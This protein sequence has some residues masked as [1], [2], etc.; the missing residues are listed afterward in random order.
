MI[1]L[2]S[3]PNTPGCYLYN[4][5]NGKI[6]YVGKAKD[7]KKR[8]S[9]YFKDNIFDPKTKILVS[10][11]KSVD[12]IVTNT[13]IEAL[14]LENNLIKKHSPK[15]NISLKDS[16]TYAFIKLTDDEFPRFIIARDREKSGDLYGPFVLASDRKNILEFINKSFKLRTCKKLP[17]KECLRFH[18]GLC[19][20][21]CISK[22]NEKD[23][24][25]LVN[26]A[27]NVLLGRNDEVENQ[28]KKELKDYSV[29]K[30]FEKAILV[31]EQLKAIN[32]LKA[33]QLIQ[34]NKSHNEH[35]IDYLVGDES[36]YFMV[37]KV[38]AGLVSSKEEFEFDYS[39]DFLTQFLVQYY[40]ENS[41]PNE[42]VLRQNLDEALL[43]YLKSKNSAIK[44]VVPKM[45]DKLKM[46]DLVKKNIKE[47]FLKNVS[48][49]NELKE[50]LSLENLPNIIEG[51]DISH[52]S[53][54]DTVASMVAF[55]KGKPEKSEYRRFKIK[56]LLDEVDDFKAMKEVV[57]RRY[58][59][60]LLENKA[61]PDL[62][63]VDGGL[64]QVSS[65]SKALKE[66]NIEIA[67]V[68]L[69]KKF[70][71]LWLPN[72]GMPINIDKK[73]EALKLLQRV[74][75][76]AHRFANN[77]NKTLRSKKLKG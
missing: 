22:I 27:K 60:L 67:I 2:K 51:F 76:E 75:D 36:V 64:G 44:V 20:A 61:L 62:I 37:F 45:A 23:Y 38:N 1:D 47:R 17:R 71:E 48:A 50:F 70:E 59:R 24:N 55:K 53:G 30:E 40:S 9:S 8:V 39:F 43:E 19:S 74:R 41:P 21:P 7:L 25:N 52:L 73:S 12:F 6:I 16:K 10:S 11:I 35:F 42:L 69:A 46:L 4:D 65:A 5:I 57:Q 58:K 31:R 77:Y 29:S 72:K 3:I 32:Y 15:Y 18:I 49:L 26:K 66:L 13:E 63:L 14:I 54:T 68:G 34:R 33:S 28:L 56:T